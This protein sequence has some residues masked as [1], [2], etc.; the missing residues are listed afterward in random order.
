MYIK[1]KSMNQILAVSNNRKSSGSVIELKKIILFFI[2]DFVA[3]S[4]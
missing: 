2:P 1:E 3:E 4:M